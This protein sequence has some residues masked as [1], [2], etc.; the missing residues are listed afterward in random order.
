MSIELSVEAIRNVL[1]TTTFDP[2]TPEDELIR[3]MFEAYFE[4][5]YKHAP[6]RNG[7]GGYT[8]FWDDARWRAFKDAVKIVRMLSE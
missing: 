6:Q 1:A 5:E 7:V 8:P 4:T 2:D 3:V